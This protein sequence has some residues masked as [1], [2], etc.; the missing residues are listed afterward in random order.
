[1][2]Y[3]RLSSLT[4]AVTMVRLES[5]TYYQKRKRPDVAVTPGLLVAA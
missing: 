5:L 1:L 2:P 3:V 4:A